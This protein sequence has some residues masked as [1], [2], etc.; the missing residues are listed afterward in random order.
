YSGH[1]SYCDTTFMLKASRPF[2]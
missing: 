1:N 2:F